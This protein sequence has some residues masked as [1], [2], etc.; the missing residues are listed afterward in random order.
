MS[1]VAQAVCFSLFIDHFK[2]TIFHD[3]PMILKTKVAVWRAWRTFTVSL[4]SSAVSSSAGPGSPTG[5]SNASSVFAEKPLHTPV[6]VKEVLHYLDIQP[7]QVWFSIFSV[8]VLLFLCLLLN[9][10]VTV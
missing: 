4:Q 8:C 2:S 3:S 9:Q 5:S 7:A 6:M 1:T 10:A